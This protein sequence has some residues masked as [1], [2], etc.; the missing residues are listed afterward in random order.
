MSQAYN[1]NLDITSANA[2]AVMTVEELFPSGIVLQ[3]FSTDAAINMD[4]IVVAETRKG[5]DGKM[6]AGYVPA[7]YPVT[8][9]LEASSPSRYSLAFVFS[10]MVTNRRP[11]VCNLVI[12]LPSVRQVYT[13]SR[14]VLREGTFL[15]N[16]GTTLQPTT[17]AFD[18]DELRSANS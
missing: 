1:T 14:G 5:V 16:L 10:A 12:T 11:Y 4:N 17:W 8:I 18:F 13:F 15:P 3:M 9:S 2:E 6:V 7:L